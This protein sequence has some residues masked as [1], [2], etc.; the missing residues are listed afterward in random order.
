MKKV[1]YVCLTLFSIHYSSAQ[2]V[3]SSVSSPSSDN[4][5]TYGIKGGLNFSTIT[6]GNFDEGADP[7][8]SYYIGF[9]SEIPL[10]NK[11][12]SL[13]PEVLYSRQGF[14][15]N[16]RLLG[17]NYK[18]EYR[19][20]YINVP[21]LAKIHLGRVLAVEAGPQFGFKINEK[22]K[23]ENSTST[24][25]DVNSFDTALAAGLS[26]KIDDFLISGRYTYSFNEVIKNT[27]SKNSVFQI[28]IGFYF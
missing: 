9:F 11:V 8:T 23:S 2:E 10:I 20:D 16:F 6:K 15:T 1:F 17:T 5:G 28:G 7:R 3:Q 13:Q 24:N 4:K 21:V 25:D 19:I 26:L 22:I 27:D 14:E 18:Q 12:L